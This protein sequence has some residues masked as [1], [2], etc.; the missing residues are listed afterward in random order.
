MSAVRVSLIVLALL[1]VAPS[2]ASADAWRPV[3]TSCVRTAASG[4]CVA[5]T[6]AEGLWNLKVGPGG[7][8]AYGTAWDAN[9]LL[10]FDRDP[11]TGKLTSRACF[12]EGGGGGCSTARGLGA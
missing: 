5:M 1:L 4:N 10:I 11:A 7:T 9:A 3:S 12:R 8:T 6:N 2:V